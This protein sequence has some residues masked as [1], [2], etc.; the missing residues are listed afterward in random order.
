MRIQSKWIVLF[1]AVALVAFRAPLVR[2]AGLDNKPI[3]VQSIAAL[4]TRL[5]QAPPREQ[6]YLYAELLHQMTELSLRQYAQGNVDG[7]IELL[8][9][10]QQTTTRLRALILQRNKH[11]LEAEILLRHSAFRLNEMLH[12]SNTEDRALVE[13]TLA[14]VNQ[15]QNATL[16]QVFKSY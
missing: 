2:A 1:V 5:H 6:C 7:A 9:R 12:N 15:T 4:E 16:M 3:D 8:H 10:V 14:Q 13:Q 11:L